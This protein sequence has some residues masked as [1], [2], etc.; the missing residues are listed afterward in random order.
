VAAPRAYN[1]PTVKPSVRRAW[2]QAALWTALVLCVLG[3]LEILGLVGLG[4]LSR[5]RGVRYEPVSALALP[6]RARARIQD[7][8]EGRTRY[9]AFSPVLGWTLRQAAVAGPYRAN[10]QGMRGDR[11]Y[12]HRPPPGVVRVA[13]FGDAFT[14]GEDVSNEE[15]WTRRLELLD[16][17]LEV[18]N[19]GVMGYA[20]DQGLLRYAEE[21]KR[22]AP[23]VVILELTPAMIGELASVFRPFSPTGSEL[24]FAKPR[25]TLEDDRLLL[26]PNPLPGRAEYVGLIRHPVPLLAQFGRYDVHFRARP[27][28]GP[29]DFYAPVRVVKLSL[30]ELRRAHADRLFVNGDLNPDSEAFRLLTRILDEFRTRVLADGAVP[31][32]LILP[33][34]DD[35][36][37]F[38]RRGTRRYEPLVDHLRRRGHL[39]LDLTDRISDRE[40]VGGRYT[41]S[42]NALVAGA[43]HDWLAREGLLEAEGRQRARGK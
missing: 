18:L 3:A 33:D 29:F 4:T 22:F 41:A 13:A 11:N 10:A 27:Q 9:I 34:Q 23:H 40:L 26:L 5:L 1:V 32:V 24:P 39:W 14:H 25:F 37:R 35:V 20:P 8:L 42:G 2:R 6:A 31:A 38:R 21:G 16:P 15:T 36:H 7:Q 17:R 28:P 30:L 43:L 12:E 19:F